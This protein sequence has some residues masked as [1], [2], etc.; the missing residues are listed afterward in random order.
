[1]TGFDEQLA[2]D[3]NG[4]EMALPR[5]GPGFVAQLGDRDLAGTSFQTALFDAIQAVE[6]FLANLF[7]GAPASRRQGRN[8]AARRGR[9]QAYK[10]LRQVSVDRARA[11]FQIQPG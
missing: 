6:N 4:R 7:L 9:S 5:F 3:F 10:L 11:G 1:P 2:T 8:S